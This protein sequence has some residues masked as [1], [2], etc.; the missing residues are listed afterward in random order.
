MIAAIVPTGSS[1]SSRRPPRPPNAITTVST[2]RPSSRIAAPRRKVISWTVI[3]T[4]EE[5]FSDFAPY[6]AAV[7]DLGMVAFQAAL[8]DGGSGVFTG[9]GEVSAEVVG[10]DVLAA[11]TSHPDLNLAGE[12]SFYGDL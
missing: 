8:R 11:V 7:N 3:A 12:T 2:N 4:T 1:A 5:Q 10:P 6:V 9:S